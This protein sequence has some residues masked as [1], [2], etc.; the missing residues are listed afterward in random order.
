V[1]FAADAVGYGES[2]GMRVDVVTGRDG[3]RVEDPNRR[4]IGDG[5]RRVGDPYRGS[6]ETDLSARETRRR[7]RATARLLMMNGVPGPTRY[8]RSIATRISMR[9]ASQ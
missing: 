2:M 3:S 8:L 6:I 5:L 4:A 9:S 1:T 7:R